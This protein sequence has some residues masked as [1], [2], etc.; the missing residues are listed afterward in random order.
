MYDTIRLVKCITK[1]NNIFFCPLKIESIEQIKPI[2]FSVEINKKISK[3]LVVG[4][5]VNN[6]NI[7]LYFLWGEGV[8]GQIII[9]KT[10]FN[11]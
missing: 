11:C 8:T 10:I 4:L 5:Y 2:Y 6:N 3:R 7:L 1:D 9:F